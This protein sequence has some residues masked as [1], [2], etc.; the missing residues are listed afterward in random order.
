MKDRVVIAAG[1][2]VALEKSLE[3]GLLYVG[4]PIKKVPQINQKE[5]DFLT[6]SAQNYV[7]LKDQYLAAE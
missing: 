4:S 3:N 5:D 1:S 2:L 7:R 6:Y